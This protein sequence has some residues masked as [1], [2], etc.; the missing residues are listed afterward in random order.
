[1]FFEFKNNNGFHFINLALSITVNK[2]YQ[3]SFL[4]ACSAIDL[5]IKNLAS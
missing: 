2:I 3:Y 5:F 1:M 4:S